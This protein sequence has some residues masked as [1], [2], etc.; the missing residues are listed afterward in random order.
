MK[1]YVSGDILYAEEFVKKFK[2]IF[3]DGGSFK[4]DYKDE[5]YQQ[6]DLGDIKN[7]FNGK[8]SKDSVMFYD[9]AKKCLNEK[10]LVIYSGDDYGYFEN[11]GSVSNER[12]YNFLKDDFKTCLRS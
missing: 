4:F 6:Y 1:L 8:A 9:K 12:M 11:G 5:D 7:I 3:K 2:A 10:S